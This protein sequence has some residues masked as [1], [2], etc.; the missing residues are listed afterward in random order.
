MSQIIGQY[1]LKV[2]LRIDFDILTQRYEN[3]SY[4]QSNF[5][6]DKMDFIKK[7]HFDQIYRGCSNDY[8][9]WYEIEPSK[10]S[11]LDQIEECFESYLVRQ[12][13]FGQIEWLEYKGEPSIT[14]NSTFCGYNDNDTLIIYH[15]PRCINVDISTEDALINKFDLQNFKSKF[16]LIKNDVQNFYSTMKN[17]D[18]ID[19]SV[20][21]EAFD[22]NFRE[23]NA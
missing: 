13:F 20:F 8:V 7:L 5:E 17:F 10:K 4:V 21:D 14:E 16:S 3:P 18:S 23:T 22:L 12:E 19:N 11:T 6:K 1:E 15:H 9:A 2:L